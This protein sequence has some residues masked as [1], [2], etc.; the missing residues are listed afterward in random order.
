M[1]DVL[2]TFD[3]DAT[4][5]LV[6]RV[7][8]TTEEIASFWTDQADIPA[9]VGETLKLGF[10]DAPLPF[11]LLLAQSDD[12]VII[13]RTATFPPQW[14]GTDIRWEISGGDETSTVTFRH[15]TFADET[16]EGRVA[17][18]WGQVMVQL[19]RYLE[20]GVAAPVFVKS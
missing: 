16:E 15:G 4:S 10:P 14:V 5:D 20:T 11:D 3:V 19:K 7:L 1:G 17:Y 2:F 6:H 18:V 12:K 8:T 13:W 9:E